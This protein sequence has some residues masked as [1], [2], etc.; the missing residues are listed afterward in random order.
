MII[1][2][3]IVT[4]AVLILAHEF[5]HF[6]FA[7]LSNTK[8][9]EFGLGLPPRIFGIKKG[10][11][12]YSLNWIPFGGFVKILGENDSV[13]G[14]PRSFSSKPAHIRAIILVAGVV[15]NVVLAFLLLSAVNVVGA[16]A[17]VGP[18][19]TDAD[20]TIVSIQQ[21]SPAQNAGLLPG[22]RIKQMTSA[23]ETLEIKTIESVQDFVSRHNGQFV[24]IDYLRGKEVL[25]TRIMPDPLLGIAM[26]RIGIVS[27]PVHKAI[28]YG[29]RDTGYLTVAI[30]K[31][32]G[33]LIADIF[34]GGDLVGQIRGPV[35][36]V[37]MVGTT[38]GLGLVYVLQFMALL[39]INLAILNMI[40]F[41]ALDGGRL[42]ILGIEKIK[43]SPI[44]QNFMKHAYSISFLILIL[45][46]LLVTYRDVARLFME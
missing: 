35:G 3:F 12:L 15:F 42:L 41:P 16:P 29:L 10:E 23:G 27:Y 33:V 25:N 20:V 44:N 6:L 32:F 31:M 34:A 5:G 19:I 37:E 9:E 22:D 36:I 39:S 24:E 1:L 21:D 30:T 28:W 40:P 11:T 43:G 2:L 14:E 45:L 4:L 17:S 7:K 46:M 8:V 13:K 38:A 18:E 26:D